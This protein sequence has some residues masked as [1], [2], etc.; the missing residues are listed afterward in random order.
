MLPL[1][2]YQALLEFCSNYK[3]SSI[4][5]EIQ[6]K[7]KCAETHRF[8][9]LMEFTLLF[10]FN[11]YHHLKIDV[12]AVSLRKKIYG[13]IIQRKTLYKGMKLCVFREY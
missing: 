13:L 11:F 7:Y 9:Y 3:S 12:L 4:I 1:R 10:T 5:L 2:N 8:S 6:Y